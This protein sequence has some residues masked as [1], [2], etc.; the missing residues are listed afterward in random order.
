M[1]IAKQNYFEHHS[2][3]REFFDTKKS[4]GDFPVGIGFDPET[5]VFYIEIQNSISDKEKTLSLSERK[6]ASILT[7]SNVAEIIK[8]AVSAT[9]LTIIEKDGSIYNVSLPLS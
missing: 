6:F 3:L 4:A 5:E 9:G 8:V 2:N 7:G 1:I